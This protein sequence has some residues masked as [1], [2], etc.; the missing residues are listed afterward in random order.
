MHGTFLGD[1]HLPPNLTHTLENGDVV[2]FGSEVTRG[3]GTLVDEE[4]VP[5]KIFGN[6]V[7]WLP[8]WPSASISSCLSNGAIPET[9][10]PLKMRVTY[11][12]NERQ[13]TRYEFPLP[14]ISRQICFTDICFD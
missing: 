9:Y 7:S 12:W 4:D 1:V 2:R 8:L 13:D 10:P 11:E 14:T 5:P 3:S 6:H